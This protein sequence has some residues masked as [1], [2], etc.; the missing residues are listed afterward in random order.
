MITAVDNYCYCCCCPRW[1]RA[2]TLLPFLIESKIWSMFK[3]AAK[4]QLLIWKSKRTG[5]LWFMWF[6]FVQLKVLYEIRL[7]A[8]KL[9]SSY[10]NNIHIY[11]IK[12]WHMAVGCMCRLCVRGF[13]QFQKFQVFY[14]CI[15]NMF[16]SFGIHQCEIHLCC[17]C[18]VNA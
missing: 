17:T 18:L 9:S 13:E 15:E 16:Y 11:L 4:L 6:W 1:K 8:N 12:P 10:V 14:H 5:K 3:Y 2:G 7:L